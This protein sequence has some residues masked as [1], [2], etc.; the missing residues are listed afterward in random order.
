MTTPASM[1]RSPRLSRVALWVTGLIAVEL[2]IA[3]A[4]LMYR[5]IVIEDPTNSAL[6][7]AGIFAVTVIG[8]HVA[9]WT[10][11]WALKSQPLRPIWAWTAFVVLMA[12]CGLTAIFAAQIVIGV[13]H[14]IN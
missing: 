6:L 14:P 11:V 7:W 2:A 13:L 8:I 4:V 10:V 9:F 1:R 5:S 12:A 3:G